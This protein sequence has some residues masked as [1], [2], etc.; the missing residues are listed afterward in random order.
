MESNRHRGAIGQAKS[1]AYLGIYVDYASF[2]LGHAKATMGY[3]A[4]SGIDRS[5]EDAH[6]HLNVAMP[7]LAFLTIDLYN[8]IELNLIIVA[9]FKINNGLYLWS[10][11]ASTNGIAVYSIGFL[12]L[13]SLGLGDNGI[14]F[15]TLIV[16]GWVT[17]V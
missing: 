9:T 5:S 14:L 1:H 3:S 17:M 13:K 11:L 16:V 15:V 10:S 8:V 12:L 7:L 4:D 2:L 6:F